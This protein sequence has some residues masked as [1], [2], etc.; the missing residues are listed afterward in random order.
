MGQLTGTIFGIVYFVVGILQF[1]AT[2]G[3][4]TDWLGLPFWLAIIACFFLAYIPVVGTIC[5]IAGA[6]VSWN[7]EWWQAGL[8]F[9]G[10]W[11]AVLAFALLGAAWE[12]GAG[13]MR[14]RRRS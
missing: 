10:P 13:Y 7:W 6:I 4:L 11:A 8:L 14:E 12:S 1:V 3:G 5:G 9:V 2:I